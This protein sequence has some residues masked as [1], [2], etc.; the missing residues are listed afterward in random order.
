MKL[1]LHFLLACWCLAVAVAAGPRREEAVFLFENRKVGIEV[2]A[3]FVYQQNKDE[4]GLI[5]V[6]L[7]APDD[8]VTLHLLFLP[9]PEGRFGTARAR[10]EKMVDLFQ[11]YVASSVEKAMQFEELEPRQGAGTYCVFTD[12]GLVGKSSLPPGEYL[13]F[14]AGLKA[15]PGVLAIVRVFSQDTASA[16]YRAVLRLLRE[17]VEEKPVPLR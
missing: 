13:H 7:A 16:E 5:N 8:K 15:W 2:P 12:A 11:E 9:D 17:S 14:T 1:T 10:T 4:L 6:Q 3:G